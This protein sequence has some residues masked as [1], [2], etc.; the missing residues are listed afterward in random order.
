M[1]AFAWRHP[2]GCLVAVFL[3]VVVLGVRCGPL[4][5]VR[6]E[7][8]GALTLLYAGLQVVSFVEVYLYELETAQVTLSHVGWALLKSTLTVI[9]VVAG[10][11]GMHGEASPPSNERLQFGVREWAWKLPLLADIFLLAMIGGGLVLFSPVAQ[12]VDP[13]ALANYEILAPPAWVLPFQL[14]RGALF[15][16]FLLLIVYLFSG[17]YRE[18]QLPSRWHSRGS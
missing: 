12:F 14:V 9:A 11:G 1:V 15:T 6:G 18:T 13:Q 10:F 2:M 17:G 4:P 3:T 5:M 8:V 16:A 7:L